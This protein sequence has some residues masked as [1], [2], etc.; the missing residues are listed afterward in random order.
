MMF[1]KGVRWG[2]IGCCVPGLLITNIKY[3]L[4]IRSFCF[5]TIAISLVHHGVAH[6][7]LFLG[8]GTRPSYGYCGLVEGCVNLITLV[9]L[10]SRFQLLCH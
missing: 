7:P 8:D 3:R 6:A 2:L 5:N 4:S 10:I 1:V 9:G